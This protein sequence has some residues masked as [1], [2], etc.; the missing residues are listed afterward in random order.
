VLCCVVL[1]CVVLCCVVLCC[2]VLCCVELLTNDEIRAEKDA[3]ANLV[4]FHVLHLAT[5]QQTC[6]VVDA[7][8]CFGE[9]RHLLQ[10]QE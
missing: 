8:Y 3:C 1:C 6:Y 4:N 9:R 7:E 2:V 10:N 5:M